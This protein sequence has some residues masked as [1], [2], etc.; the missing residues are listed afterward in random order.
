MAADRRF[1]AVQSPG[2]GRDDPGYDSV[3]ALAALYVD[4]LMQESPGPLTIGGYSFGGVVAFELARQ[5]EARGR[6]VSRVA[7]ID[8]PAPTG[9]PPPDEDYSDAQWLL[10]MLRVRERFHHVDLALTLEELQGAGVPDCYDLVAAR[11]SEA[12]LL[13]EGADSDMLMRMTRVGQRHYA[14]YRAYR[15]GRIA[16]P[17]AVIRAGTLDASEGEIDW[18]GRFGLADLGWGEL[19]TGRVLTAVTPGDHVTMMRPPAVADLARTLN[20]LLGS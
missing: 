10:R 7:I 12:G 19:T 1:V 2:L 9:T 15:P 20:L 18:A 14:H 5:L 4:V 11:L 17:L 8:T 16:A 3:E 6:S 13:P